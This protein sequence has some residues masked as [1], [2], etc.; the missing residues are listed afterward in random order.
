[1]CRD[2]GFCPPFAG[3]PAPRNR[4]ASRCS[5]VLFRIPH[6]PVQLAPQHRMR[7]SSSSPGRLSR[8]DGG[9]AET[10]PH[11]TPHSD[12]CNTATPPANGRTATERCFRYGIRPQSPSGGDHRFPPLP[13]PGRAGRALRALLPQ[14][15]TAAAPFLTQPRT[16]GGVYSKRPTALRLLHSGYMAASCYFSA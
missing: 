13:P 9:P 3:R 12:R 6:Q 1:M 8:P 10:T 5:C 14:P 16:A 4:P 11:T 15:V 7:P 2:N